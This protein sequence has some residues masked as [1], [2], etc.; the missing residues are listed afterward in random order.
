MNAGR[1][2]AVAAPADNL[3]VVNRYYDEVWNR[4]DISVLEEVVQPDLVGHDVAG[5]D[6]DCQRLKEFVAMFRRAFPDFRTRAEQTVVHGD[7]VALI[8][9]SE[10]TLQG[11]FMGLEPAGRHASWSGLVVY[12]FA[13]GKIA[14]IWT[15]WDH[16]RLLAE[17]AT[18][19]D[20]SARLPK[21]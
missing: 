10:G 19:V 3:A 20:G 18:P 9:R 15:Q 21:R 11:E 4:G 16:R 13:Y 14:E 12:R 6:Y 17:L 7:E 5:G 8:F 1:A 2:P